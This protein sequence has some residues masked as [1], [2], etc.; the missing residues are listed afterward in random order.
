[1]EA[2]GQFIG[3]SSQFI[4]NPDTPGSVW[5]I[6]GQEALPAKKEAYGSVYGESGQ[7][8]GGVWKMDASSGDGEAHA[9]GLFEGSR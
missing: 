5:Q 7:R 6:D 3:D 1:M 9:T 8:I 2:G 4:I